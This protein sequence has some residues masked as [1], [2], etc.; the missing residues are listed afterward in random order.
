M[1]APTTTRDRSQASP[2][3]S[4][5]V[6]ARETRRR[7]PPGL[8]FLFTAVFALFGFAVGIE[9]LSDNSFFTHLVTGRYILDHGIP[10]HDSYSF[11]A[12]G[13]KFVAQSWLAE[14]LYGILDRTVGPFGIRVLGALTGAA[15][16]VLAFRLAL[17]LARDRVRAALISV[18][19]LSGLYMLWSERPLLLGLLFFMIVLWIVEVPDCWVGRHPYVSMPVAF[20]LW[21]NVHGTFALGF[22]YLGLHLLGRWLD[23]A[24]PWKDRKSTRLN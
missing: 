13:T 10:H 4:D 20:W 3:P 17:R 1:T 9:R 5:E 14:L 24:R 6:G 2:S 8:D 23:G 18:A 12:P 7:Q 11:T 16:T 15:I 21:A 19:A 22:L